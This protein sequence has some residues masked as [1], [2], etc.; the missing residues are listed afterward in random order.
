MDWKLSYVC[1]EEEFC[2][3]DKYTQGF[4]SLWLNVGGCPD[5]AKEKA[6]LLFKLKKGGGNCPYC[7]EWQQ[8]K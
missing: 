5:A 6:K 1:K 8:Q 3:T 4:A 2:T 7:S